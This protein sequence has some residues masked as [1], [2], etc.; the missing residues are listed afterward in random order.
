[1]NRLRLIHRLAS[2]PTWRISCSIFISNFWSSSASL[3]HV[4]WWS[5]SLAG[6]YNLVAP[7]TPR[8]SRSWKTRMMQ[9]RCSASTAP[10]AKTSSR[11]SARPTRTSESSKS[12]MSGWTTFKR[13]QL[14]ASVMFSITLSNS[15][16][17]LL[18]FQ[19][20]QTTLLSLKKSE[21]CKEGHLSRLVAQTKPLLVSMAM[22][23]NRPVV[24]MIRHHRA[25][26]KC[27]A[28]KARLV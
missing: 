25:P 23:L 16:A 9:L 13:C 28:T 2:T 20:S 5:A 18:S 1:M 14:I 7:W 27:S 19:T 22:L 8:S 10:T 26:R 24:S 4:W 17:M 3:C 12:L 11:T 6:K 15:R 21:A